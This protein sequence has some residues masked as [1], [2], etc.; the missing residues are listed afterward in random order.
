MDWRR[1]DGSALP[2]EKRDERFTD[3][4]AAAEYLESLRWPEGVVCPHCGEHERAPYRL[5]TRSGRRRLWKCRACRKQFTA[6]VGTAFESSHIPLN[7]WLLTVQLLSTSTEGVGAH[8]LEQ[9]LDV[10]YTTAVSMINRLGRALGNSMQVVESSIR[11]DVRE[12][13]ARKRGGTA[14]GRPAR[15]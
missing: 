13:R 12:A 1:A 14:R 7:K 3:P 2:L 10:A 4:H 15:A 6:T 8:Q 11:P 5:Q 9:E